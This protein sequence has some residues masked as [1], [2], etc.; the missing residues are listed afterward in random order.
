M[1]GRKPDPSARERG[2][3]RRPPAL[4]ELPP[5][6]GA[7]SA[8][9][10]EPPESLPPEAHDHWRLMVAELTAMRLLHESDLPMLEMLVIAALR[11]R[12]ASE[13]IER[14][15]VL[16]KGQRGPLVNPALKAERDAAPQ[17]QRLSEALGLSPAARLRFGLARLSGESLVFSLR[18]RL[19]AEVT[20]KG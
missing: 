10:V 14:A 17:Y 9:S 1:K 8:E 6:D 18:D 3:G 13:V 15:G 12:Q 19:I 5:I 2:T 20:Q 4:A 7:L 11:H 16:V